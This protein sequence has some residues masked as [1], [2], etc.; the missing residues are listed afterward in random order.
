M[1]EHDP[2]H[3]ACP[4]YQYYHE[5][6]ASYATLGA[7]YNGCVLE[8][9]PGGDEAEQMDC[10]CPNVLTWLDGRIENAEQAY[11]DDRDEDWLA[12]KARYEFV[13]ESL[14]DSYGYDFG[15]TQ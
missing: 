10:Q 2:H 12:D 8:W 11:G 6:I 1:I 13:R 7:S 4:A 9:L 15:G 5:V 3:P 14:L